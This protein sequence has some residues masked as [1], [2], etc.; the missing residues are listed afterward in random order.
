MKG[1][2][3]LEKQLATHEVSPGRPPYTLRDVNHVSDTRSRLSGV[4]G[5]RPPRIFSVSYAFWDEHVLPLPPHML[6]HWGLCAPAGSTCGVLSARWRGDTCT[7]SRGWSYH[8]SRAFLLTVR[9]GHSLTPDQ[10]DGEATVRDLGI[11]LLLPPRAQTERQAARPLPVRVAGLFCVDFL[12]L[13]AT[14]QPHPSHLILGQHQRKHAEATRL[15]PSWLLTLGNSLANYA[16]T[17]TL[18]TC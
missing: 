14:G 6:C 15:L 3:L 10:R 8:R 18:V 12:S 5:L 11:D 16:L 2:V 13:I 4:G 7:L 17:K 9:F 1:A